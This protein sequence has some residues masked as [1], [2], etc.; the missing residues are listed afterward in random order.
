MFRDELKKEKGAKVI[1]Y[2]LEE[3]ENERFLKDS[4]AFY[5]QL[6]SEV[7]PDVNVATQF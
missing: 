7:N 1:A 3:K 2:N 5:N 4:D 6:M